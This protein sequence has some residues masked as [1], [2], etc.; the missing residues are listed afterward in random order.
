[1]LIKVIR[2]DIFVSSPS[3]L[4]EE[5]KIIRR[6]IEKLNRSSLR[7]SYFLMP[8]L[9]EDE[10]PPEIGEE[11]QVIVDRY[12]EV[13]NSYILI[14]LLWTRMGTPFTIIETNERYESGTQ[15][16]IL[17]GYENFQIN[18]QPHILLYKKEKDNP[19]ADPLQK[20]KVEKF[21]SDFI[22]DPPKIKG[23]F[24]KFNDAIEFEEK[25]EDHL[26]KLLKSYP[27]QSK[28]SLWMDVLEFKEEP[29]RIDAAM[30][31]QTAV[32]ENTPVQVMICLPNSDGLKTLLPEATEGKYEIEKRDVRAGGLTIAYP[33]DQKTGR[34]RSV[35]ATI[36]IDAPDFKI[37][38]NSIKIQLAP[39]SDS[40]Q[41]TFDLIPLY[42]RKYSMVIVR[43]KCNALDGSEIE[44]GSVVLYTVIK[45]TRAQLSSSIIWDLVSRS[46][47]RASL[48]NEVTQSEIDVARMEKAIIRSHSY[49]IYSYVEAGPSGPIFF[50]NPQLG[51]A[52]IP[53]KFIILDEVYE[54]YSLAESRF[55]NKV[56]SINNMKSY[57]WVKVQG[58][59]MNKA[60]PVPICDGD[61]I[62]FYQ[63][64]HPD[65]RDIVIASLLDEADAGNKFVV[66]RFY[67]DELRSES[68][69]SYPPIILTSNTRILGIVV[70]IAK[71]ESGA[72]PHNKAG[73]Q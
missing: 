40:G 39:G 17:K 8:L 57:G 1:M 73:N 28:D 2:V 58:N 53:G 32:G 41:I 23:L 42:S 48:S 12:M 62:L 33:I 27:P 59:S 13:K 11:A 5:R 50:E 70:A 16:E 10:V 29:R 14:S 47:M 37:K 46:L 65:N 26:F 54:I 7:D 49:P 56:I 22:G 3:D 36:E 51:Y 6:V 30:P 9:Y 18:G 64:S 52:E 19:S 66:K 71:L 31:R 72:L 38:N 60:F 43:L 34:L 24:A 45:G 4:L 69:H 21:F 55:G 25:I 68:T 15:Y 20:E 63:S 44:C 67:R 35:F 61:Y